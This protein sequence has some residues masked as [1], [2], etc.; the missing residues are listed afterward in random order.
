M[1]KTEVGDRWL[2]KNFKY[3]FDKGFKCVKNSIIDFSSVVCN[4]S[5]KSGFI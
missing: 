3:A 5:L 4:M 1:D 2:L